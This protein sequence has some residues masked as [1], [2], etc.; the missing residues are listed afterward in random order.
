MYESAGSPV[1]EI[2]QSNPEVMYGAGPAGSLLKSTDGG[3]LW[4]LIG[5][6]DLIR[7]TRVR[8]NAAETKDSSK[9]FDEWPTDID[10]IAIDPVDVNRVYLATSKGILRTENGGDSWCILS[11]GIAKARAIHSIVIVPAMPDVLLVGTYKGLMRSTDR[12]CHWE[13]I[14]I[15]S[16]VRSS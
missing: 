3:K 16:Q 1:L 10:D 13:W 14:D 9:P 12:G 11:I 15:L 8:R 4:D 6:N 7:K 2:S 5:Q